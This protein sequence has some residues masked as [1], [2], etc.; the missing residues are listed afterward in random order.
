MIFYFL[1]DLPFQVFCEVV[2]M[3]N[4]FSPL[5]TNNIKQIGLGLQILERQGEIVNSLGGPGALEETERV[6]R[7]WRK[8]NAKHP[9]DQEDSGI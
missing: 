3:T 8:Y 6:C 5:I 7:N 2:Q 4:F 9:I 1:L